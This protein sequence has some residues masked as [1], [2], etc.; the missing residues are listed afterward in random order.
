MLNEDGGGGGGGGSDEQ[1]PNYCEIGNKIMSISDRAGD[2]ALALTGTGLG[3]VLIGAVAGNPGV[4]SGG[5][6]VATAG[7]LIGIGA[8]GLQIVGGL[9]QGVGGGGYK[10][11]IAGAFSLGTGVIV[12][13]ALRATVPRGWHNS[14]RDTAVRNNNITGNIVG[15]LMDVSEWLAPSQADCQR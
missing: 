4:I 1:G 8:G 3:I 6:A 10:N 2:G 9:A 11:A 12:S 5:S 15:V 13:K 14:L 7:S